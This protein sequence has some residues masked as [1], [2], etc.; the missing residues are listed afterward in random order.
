[1]YIAKAS[2]DVSCR[3]AVLINENTSEALGQ[4]ASASWLLVSL[5]CRCLLRHCCWCAAASPPWPCGC[6]VPRHGAASPVLQA[7]RG[8]VD[9]EFPGMEQHLLCCK[10]PMAMWMRSSQAWSS[11]SCV[12]CKP[13]VA[14]WMRSS[15][16]G[17]AAPALC[18]VWLWRG[19]SVVITTVRRT[20]VLF[21]QTV[22]NPW[23]FLV[24][25]ICVSY[26]VFW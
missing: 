15:Q 16:T 1:M 12:C 23:F 13:P 25:Y 5:A 20:R 8:H 21:S 4:M 6:W 24:T 9:A 19:C 17:A 2:C 14:M 10:P 3:I 11:S 22:S 26:Q 18:W 7:P